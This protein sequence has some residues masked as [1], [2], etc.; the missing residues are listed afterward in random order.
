MVVAHIHNSTRE[1]IDGP[2]ETLDD[3]HL[4]ASLLSREEQKDI[5]ITKNV[6]GWVVVDIGDQI[7][8]E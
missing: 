7:G 3:A 5:G 8:E 4:A 2:Y 1:V 6:D